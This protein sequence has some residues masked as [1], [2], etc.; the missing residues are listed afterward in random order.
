M[1][2][3][4]FGVLCARVAVARPC[5]LAHQDGSGTLDITELENALRS[6]RRGNIDWE[7]LAQTAIANRKEKKAGRG[8]RRPA[9]LVPPSARASASVRWGVSLARAI[10]LCRNAPRA[11]PGNLASMVQRP[12]SQHPFA[13]S[14]V[15]RPLSRTRENNQHAVLAAAQRP[16]TRVCS[17]VSPLLCRGWARVCV[18]R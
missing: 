11:H 14:V 1:A 3:F 16:P 8:R 5:T 12:P 9:S 13:T 18:R 15:L 4:S 10:A 2:H 7:A 6:H 17:A